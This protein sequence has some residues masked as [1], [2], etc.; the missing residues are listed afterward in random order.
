M[1]VCTAYMTRGLQLLTG[2]H[3]KA[4]A[5]RAEELGPQD[6][7]I[8][9]AN[10]PPALATP[11]E[12][13]GVSAQT[14]TVAL[15]DLQPPG[16]ARGPSHIQPISD[17]GSANRDSS[18]QETSPSPP[19]L[20]PQAPPSPP[21]A[22]LWAT[23]VQVHLDEAVYLTLLLFVGLPVYYVSGYAMPLHL[24]FNVLM[25]FA[26]LSLPLKWKQVLHPV[27]VSAFFTVMGIWVFGLIR[28]QSLDVNLSEYSTGKKY[29]QLWEHATTT[30]TP[31]L[32]PGAGDILGTILDASIVALALPMYQYR[33]ELVEHFVAI[34]LPNIVL[35]VG[36]LYAYPSVCFAI[37]I[38]AARSLAF[39][40]R[41]LT[42]ALAI[43]ATENLGGDRNTVAAVAI[44]SGIVGALIGSKVLSWLKIP[45]GMYP[46]QIS[47]SIFRGVTYIVCSLGELLSS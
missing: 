4:V 5:A 26:A 35:S 44:M 31:Y 43:P 15:H 30:T 6:D 39:A 14:S 16:Y 38:S 46:R 1:F 2:S 32:Y 12:S 23:I 13:T 25:Y 24:T 19:P 37:G 21:R 33:R 22:R 8:P 34:I 27:L 7:E 36:S 17:H 29:L 9:M 20:P 41:S 47:S 45:E 11:S 18:P 10:T 40:S 3:K 42:L 28:H